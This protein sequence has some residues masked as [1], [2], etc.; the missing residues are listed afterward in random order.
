MPV[1]TVTPPT[2]EEIAHLKQL[3]PRLMQVATLIAEGKNNTA[4][5]DALNLSPHSVKNYTNILFDHLGVEGRTTGRIEVARLVIWCQALAW[6]AE[7][8]A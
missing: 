3:T 1:T 6:L 8:T 4:I 2:P 5:G 7:R